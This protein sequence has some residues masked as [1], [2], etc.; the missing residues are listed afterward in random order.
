MY[1]WM[2]IIN[3]LFCFSSIIKSLDSFICLIVDHQIKCEEKNFYIKN[4]SRL[5]FVVWQTEND[6]I[7]SFH[8]IVIESKPDWKLLSKL[9]YYL[10]Y[11]VKKKNRKQSTFL[12]GK[13]VGLLLIICL[14]ILDQGYAYSDTYW[15]IKKNI[16][17]LILFSG[18]LFWKPLKKD[19][20][21]N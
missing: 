1:V 11:R 12:V 13:K 9:F 7:I 20:L 4:I 16:V 17:H 15:L 21:S 19:V 14:S 3:V 6:L 18:R 2:I 10:K 5:F 8:Q